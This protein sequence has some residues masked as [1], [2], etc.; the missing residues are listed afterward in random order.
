VPGLEK[1]LPAQERVILAV[2]TSE[3]A[4]ATRLIAVAKDAGARAVKMGLEIS[5]AE[6][7]AWCSRTTGRAGVDWVADAK[8]D[9]ISNTV[10]GAVRNI[11]RLPHPPVGITIH[12]NSGMDSM[13]A[14]QEIA[15]AEGIT[16]LGVTHLTSIKDDE[17][18][19]V[20]NM[21]RRPLV[22]KRALSA[23]KAGIGG[24]V[25]APV[26]VGAVIQKRAEL[27]DMITMIPGVRST[28]AE[29][30]DQ[31]NTGTPFQAIYDGADLLVIGRQVTGAEDPI[32]AY[33]AVVHE[34]QQGLNAVE[35]G[36]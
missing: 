28:G 36:Y 12:T 6:S 32:N 11:S 17:T 29:V 13:K 15:E 21:L 18:K 27:R 24:L 26:E 20:Y 35:T 8:I 33:Q 16:M 23:A 5:T 10:A 7:W 4:V 1:G 2:D 14:A 22:R 19:L 34:I 9:D 30:H 31:N 3:R 25:A